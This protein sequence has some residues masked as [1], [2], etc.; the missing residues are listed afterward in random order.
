MSVP[1]EGNGSPPGSRFLRGAPPPRIVEGQIDPRYE[2]TRELLKTPVTPVLFRGFRNPSLIGNLWSTRESVAAGYGTNARGLTEL[3]LSAI[4]HPIAPVV[5]REKAPWQEQEGAPRLRSWPVPHYYPEDAGPYFTAAIYSSLWKGKRN[6][7]YHRL[8]VRED[9]GGPVRLVPR[10]LDQMVQASRKEGIELPVTIFVG[11]PIDVLLAAACSVDYA[12]DEMEIASALHQKRTGEPLPVV[13][14]DDG[15]RVPRDAEIVLRAHITSRDEEEGPF[16]DILGTYDARR[17]Q[18]VVRVDRVYTVRDPVLHAIL[19]GSD[20][21]FLLMGL[22][23]EP[24]I[25]RAV[26]SVVPGVQDVRLTEGGC[27]WLNGVVSL[28]KR[29]EGDGKNALL[30]AFSGHPSMKHVTVVDEDID[31]F[32]DREVEWAIATRLQAD[33]GLVIVPG[34][35]GSSLDPSATPDGITTKWGIDATLPVGAPRAPFTKG[36]L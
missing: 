26:R 36:H 23:R 35:T 15:T 25:L 29:R 11:A 18:P 7:S 16:L 33:R 1:K 24:M 20:E 34:A 13:E 4:E 28:R 32:N 5:V 9:S 22:P 2:V 17:R 8:W 27:G 12:Q 6:L 30:A 31:I 19:P 14:L 3:L 21:H 10:H